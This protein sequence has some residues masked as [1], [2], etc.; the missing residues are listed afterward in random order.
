[1]KATDKIQA[2]LH[3]ILERPGLSEFGE[4]ASFTSTKL[5]LS[6]VPLPMP[7]TDAAHGVK[8]NRLLAS[9]WDG[10]RRSMPHSEPGHLLPPRWGRTHQTGSRGPAGH[11]IHSGG[12]GHSFTKAGHSSHSFQSGDSSCSL[13]MAW[14]PSL[15]ALSH[16][17]AH[18]L[19]HQTTSYSL[20]RGLEP[21]ALKNPPF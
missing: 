12:S 5:F 21:G 7:C 2:H 4:S 15:P 20:S 1:M 11:S 8:V 9:P 18:S 3:Q 6:A 16:R 19:A 10:P 14:L 13:T 17:E